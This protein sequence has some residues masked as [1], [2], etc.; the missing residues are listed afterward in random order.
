MSAVLLILTIR[1]TP[2]NSSDADFRLKYS[3]SEENPESPLQEAVD[4]FLYLLRKDSVSSA[5]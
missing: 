3:T 5:S 1:K 4:T 2:I